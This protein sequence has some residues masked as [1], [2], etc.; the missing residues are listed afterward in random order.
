MAS[1]ETRSVAGAERAKPSG[2]I[3]AA[4]KQ[5]PIANRKLGLGSTGMSF[6]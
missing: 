5:N 2:N 3:D 4:A 1:V 6:S